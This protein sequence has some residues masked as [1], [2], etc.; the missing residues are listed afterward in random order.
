VRV[1]LDTHAF[2][3]WITDDD[4]LSTLAREAIG[5]PENHVFVSAASGWEVI[6]KY[7]IGRLTLPQPVDGFI[8]QHLE[9]NAFQPLSITMRHTFELEA[10][11]SLHRD[12]FD[13]MLIAQAIAEEMPLV[14]GDQAI[15][16][17]P[18]STIW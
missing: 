15:R 17:Y 18:V 14:T 6:T 11:P 4:R 7:R 9:E 12:P 16:A 13:R 3:W 1:L 5:A 8:A 2:L 10:L